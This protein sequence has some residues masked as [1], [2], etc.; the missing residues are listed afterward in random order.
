MEQSFRLQSGYSTKNQTLFAGFTVRNFG[1]L[2]GGDTTGKQAPSGYQERDW[3]LKMKLKLAEKLT[4]KL[5]SQKVTQS[6]V[7]LY[8]KVRLENFNYY[9]FDPQQLQI[10]YANLEW[11][12]GTKLVNQ[13]DFKL[14]NKTSREG[15][16]YLKNNSSLKYAEYDQVQSTG[17][18]ANI[19]SIFSNLW[20]ATSGIEYYFDKVQSDRKKIDL[21]SAIPGSFIL[22]RG[23]Y[24]NNAKQHNLS[25]YTM[26]HLT[27]KK[28]RFEPGLRYNIFTN[29]L[30]SEF[31]LLDATSPKGDV[32][33][34]PI[35]LVGNLA[36]LYKISTSNTLYAAFS[37]GYRAPNVDDMGSLGLVDFR[38]EVPSYELKPEKSYHTEIGYR[39]NS[40]QFNFNMAGYYMH[41]QDL[42]SRV[43]KG[44]DSIQGYPVYIKTND[45]QGFIK[46]FES[47]YTFYLNKAFV[48][49]GFISTQFGQNFTRNEPMRRIPP[50]NGLNSLS[51]KIMNY[52]FS[53][54][55][56]WASRQTRLAQGDKDDNRIPKGGTPGWQLWNIYMG[57]QTR[58]FNL[59]M[60]F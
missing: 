13:V 19:H 30:P 21:N 36:A 15:R 59:Q 32:K 20:T 3:E 9:N 37:S 6:S 12:K 48:L 40:S 42:I 31:T 54:E 50:T 41:I 25:F 18:V 24:P 27:F 22:E 5:S 23:L 34:R 38:Y 8:H 53:I 10:S 16:N 2:I 7:P 14:F 39:Y 52:R 35:S 28:W 4:L 44:T 45:Q 33:Q 55:H 58:F 57:Y 51:Y 17:F 26:H 47:D 49:K 11:I 56:Q 1:D 46:G 29:V 60:A 43:R